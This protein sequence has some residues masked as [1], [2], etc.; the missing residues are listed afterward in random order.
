MSK[1]LI[2]EPVGFRIDAMQPKVSFSA[3]RTGIQQGNTVELRWAVEDATDVAFWS[4][5]LSPFESEYVDW[6]R[7][8]MLGE[9]VEP[10][11]ELVASP[12]RTTAYYLVARNAAGIAGKREL[13][14]LAGPREEAE[15]LTWDPPDAGDPRMADLPYMTAT[16]AW[17]PAER[18]QDYLWWVTEQPEISAAF[19][20]PTV[21]FTI[22]PAV[23]FTNETATATW[24]TANALTVGTSYSVSSTLT[25]VD[26]DE[27]SG[28]RVNGG[29]HGGGGSPP[30]Y[31]GVHSGQWTL[32]SGMWGW[33]PSHYAYGIF[34][35]S[36]YGKSLTVSRDV[37]VL[38]VPQFA[39]NAT[40]ERR[41]DT[42]DAIRLI[43]RRLRGGRILNDALLDNSVAAFRDHQLDRRSFW[44]R[45]LTEIHNLNL[46]TFNCIQGVSA[47][48]SWDDYKNEIKLIW[49]PTHAPRLDY[50]IAHELIHKCGFHG[51]LTGY[52]AAEIEQQAHLVTSAVI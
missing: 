16:P 48:G 6:A 11:G 22:V 4:D 33:G 23:I 39:G 47:G 36:P 15:A 2:Q 29:S 7:I 24:S 40:P 32:N 13:V 51:G 52:T 46:V 26:T 19:M 8:S 41:R 28:T 34:V 50:V 45:L 18:I 31:E 14:T 30:S 37:D 21:N 27:R 12:E 38:G 42:R 9:K 44:G 17:K 1:S 35:T 10:I 49:S 3:D 25:V 43:T 20:F 5:T